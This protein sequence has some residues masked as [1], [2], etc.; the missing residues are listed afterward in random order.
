MNTLDNTDLVE[1]LDSFEGSKNIYIPTVDSE[2]DISLDKISNLNNHFLSELQS[3]SKKIKKKCRN[4]YNSSKYMINIS[5]NLNLE[6]VDSTYIENESFVSSFI[7][8]ILPEYSSEN[9]ESKR[10]SINNFKQRLAYDLDEKFLYD[11]FNYKKVF[12]KHTLQH[13]LLHNQ[14]NDNYNI[15]KYIADYF[16][17]DILIIID[18]LLITTNTKVQKPFMIFTYLNNKFSLL[19]D[20]NG[21]TLFKINVFDIL[22]LKYDVIIDKLQ[23]KTKYKA[24]NIMQIANKL[25]I[26]TT[27]ETNG[28][29]RNKKKD[30]VYDLVQARL[31]KI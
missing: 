11:K 3:G 26:E 24:D 30:D 25:N 31:S 13:D 8:G 17:I 16:D 12:K 22:K 29:I 18:N 21:K 1:L 10:K 19:N 27:I 14:N 23:T 6:V 9:I 2:T 28:K 4:V 5:D 20:G 15:R 7:S